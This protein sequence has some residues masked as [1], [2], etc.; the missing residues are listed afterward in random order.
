MR[1]GALSASRRLGRPPGLAVVL[2]GDRP[3]SR[4][5]VRMK[6]RACEECGLA[7][8]GTE[9]GGDVSQ[10]TVLERIRSL[11]ADPRVDGILIQL[12]LPSHLDEAAVL[13]EVDPAKDVDGLHPANVARLAAGG[14]GGGGGA[15]PIDWT[16]LATVPF[17]LPCTPQGCLELLDRSG[18]PL[19]GRRAAV[20]GRSNL[21]G[22]PVALLLMHRNA[23]V[24]VVH[25]R[26]TDPHLVTREADVVV[27]AA[28]RAGLVGAE[29]IRTGAAVIDVGINAVDDSDARRGYRLVGDVNHGEVRDVAGLLTPVPGGVGPMTIA[30]L[31]RNTLNA[32]RRRLQEEEEQQQQQQEEEVGEEGE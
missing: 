21:V 19:E 14:G 7:S 3:D 6:E 24:T 32:C 17:H 28:G 16:D 30:M 4:T 20:V 26:T 2:V 18:V 27:A 25:S 1:E 22:L 31:L 9:Y 10:D 15:E 5:Y 8:Y 29:W 13:A 12:P 23:T 11:N